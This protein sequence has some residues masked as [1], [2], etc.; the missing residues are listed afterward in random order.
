MTSIGGQSKKSRLS[1]WK[2]EQALV[3][4][5]GNRLDISPYRR[6]K[7]DVWYVVKD[8]QACRA[9]G[10]ITKRT[11][12]KQW[13]FLA[14][15]GAKPSLEDLTDICNFIKQKLESESPLAR[16]RNKGCGI[17]LKEMSERTGVSPSHLSEIER[18]RSVP[19][20]KTVVRLAKAYRLAIYDFYDMLYSAER[21]YLE[22]KGHV[23]TEAE[24]TKQQ[25]KKG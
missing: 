16:L 18:G 8:R 20:F 24:E 17:T 11:W 13:R 23:A 10:D 3:T 14:F 1:W 12:D 15:R 7:G 9:I 21:A 25:D 22:E 2:N 5:H 4:Y 6:P 19:P